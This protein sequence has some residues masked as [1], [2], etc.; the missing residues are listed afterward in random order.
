MLAT[1]LTYRELFDRTPL[2]EEVFNAIESMQSFHTVLFTARLNALFRHSNWNAHLNGQHA[3]ERLQYWAA[4]VLLDRETKQ[5]LEFRLGSHC[6]EG[7]PFIH[8]LQLLQ[9]IRLALTIGHG[10]DSSRPDNSEVCRQR[11]GSACLMV[12]DLFLTEE[13]EQNLKVGNVDQRRQQLML[14]LLPSIEISNPTPQRNLL[15]RAY[16]TYRVVLRDPALVETIRNECGGLNIEQEFE[17][18]IGIP[19]KDW[20][21]LAF[22]VQ[23]LWMTRSSQ[24][25]LDDSGAFLINRKTL[26]QNSRLSQEQ[27]DGFFDALSMPF[28]ELQSEV[29]RDRRVDQRLDLVPFKSKPFFLVSPDTYACIDFSLVA[30]KLHNGPYFLLANSLPETERWKILN[31]WGFLFEAYVN[32]ILSG[33]DGRDSLSFH[34]DTSWEHDGRKSFDGVL[35]RGR[36][37]VVMEHKGGFLNQNARYSNTLESLLGDLQTK[38]GKGCKQ[39]AR[40]IGS[41][42]PESG[43]GKRLRG[44]PISLDTAYVLPILV[45]QDLMLRGPFINYFLNQR[46]ASELSRFKIQRQIEVLPLTVIQITDLE[47]LVEMSE[48]G[49]FDMFSFLHRRC[50]EDREVLSMIPEFV[51]SKIPD[52]KRCESRRFQELFERSSNE[53]CSSLFRDIE[54]DSSPSA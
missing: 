22:G 28:D 42:F 26:L 40:D 18:R 27:I 54:S 38:I 2:A 17:E 29:Q 10:D 32:W 6:I 45:V 36:F 19:L 13:E 37:V 33:L 14:Q 41:L 24:Q 21:S 9:I 35:L 15:I 8:P 25:L 31:A 20:L 4:S 48:S 46:F 52:V 11:F 3:P 44:V 53:M 16:A 30:E 43:E 7:R 47:D 49:D 39:L 50:N 23:A 34:A 5:R 12:S 1:Y 51:E